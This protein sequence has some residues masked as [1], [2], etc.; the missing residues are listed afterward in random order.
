MSERAVHSI[1]GCPSSPFPTPEKPCYSVSILCVHMYTFLL[2]CDK[3]TML[4]QVQVGSHGA[5]LSTP[6]LFMKIVSE[7]YQ[8]WKSPDAIANSSSLV[9]QNDP[10]SIPTTCSNTK[11]A[12]HTACVAEHAALGE[13][14]SVEHSS[15]MMCRRLTV[16]AAVCV[17][18][19]A[20]QPSNRLFT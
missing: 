19:L 9:R 17:P 15:R 20:G 11:H 14:S 4:P 6:P 12:Q 5:M 8:S 2:I 3:S 13:S 1:A 16:I 10:S 18:H 7:T